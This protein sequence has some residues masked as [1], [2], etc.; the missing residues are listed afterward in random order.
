[1]AKAT[2]RLVL[3]LRESA[4]RLST[5]SRYEWG[6]VGRCNCGHLAQSATGRSASQIIKT[7]G[8]QLDEW[9]EH[10]N[11][12]CGFT[13]FPVQVIFDDLADI[14]FYAEDVKNLEYLK[15]E[16]VLRALPAEKRHL[17]HNCREDVALYMDTMASLLE[18]DL[19]EA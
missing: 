15:D 5:G 19:V 3:A 2:K 13:G 16:R 14:G 18:E 9:S 11:D 10:A 8:A 7:F 17:R 1:M 6:H 4:D 12:Y